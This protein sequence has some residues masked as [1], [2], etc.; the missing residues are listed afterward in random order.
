MMLFTLD[1]L[2]TLATLPQSGF[3]WNIND[4]I[5]SMWPLGRLLGIFEL[6]VTFSVG[7]RI[8]LHRHDTPHRMEVS[9]LTGLVARHSITSAV[10]HSSYL[11][12]LV[13]WQSTN[14]SLSSL[15]K[16]LYTEQ[17]IHRNIVSAFRKK[18]NITNCRYGYCKLTVMR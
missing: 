9:Q 2:F 16:V 3:E 15:E 6:L 5:L 8:V 17:P 13:K 12:D 7:A 4:V 14:T 1:G 18:Y 11:I 10:L